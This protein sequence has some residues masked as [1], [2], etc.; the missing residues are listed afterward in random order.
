VTPSTTAP[1]ETAPE[2]SAI[3]ESVRVSILLLLRVF[4]VLEVSLVP[5]Q[6]LYV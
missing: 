6:S 4:P 3:V 5:D 1:I 2:A